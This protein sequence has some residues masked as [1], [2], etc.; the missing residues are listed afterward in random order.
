MYDQIAVV[1]NLSED[2]DVKEDGAEATEDKM[3]LGVILRHTIK[4][5]CLWYSLFKVWEQDFISFA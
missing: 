2:E 5:Q 3:V 1:E 4:Q